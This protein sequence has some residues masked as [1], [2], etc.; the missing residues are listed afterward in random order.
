VLTVGNSSMTCSDRGEPT[1]VDARAGKSGSNPFDLNRQSY[2]MIDVS[3]QHTADSDELKPFNSSKAALDLGT[4]SVTKA[5]LT[6]GGDVLGGDQSVAPNSAAKNKVRLTTPDRATHDLTAS[7]VVTYGDGSQY[8]ALFDVTALVAQAGSGSYQVADIQ[9]A[10]AV[11]GF[12][13]W[14]LVVVTH[15]PTAPL[16]LLAVIGANTTI[17]ETDA[18]RVTVPMPTAT[19]RS[20]TLAS[21]SYEGELGYVGETLS[22]NGVAVSNSANPANNPFNSSVRGATDPSNVNGFGVDADQFVV[23]TSGADVTVVASSTFDL[24]RIATIAMAV[25]LGA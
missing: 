20:V 25:D 2:S 4:S 3:S 13:G 15:D 24:V 22:I 9:T 8:T 17:N 21:T 23:N 7:S 1:C 19:A 11:Q 10:Q 16:R 5:F 14:Q 6:I 18:Y 12:A